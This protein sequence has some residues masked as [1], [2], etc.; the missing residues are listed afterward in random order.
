MRARAKP[1]QP[2]KDER[3]A[4]LVAYL[5]EAVEDLMAGGEAYSDL[6][7]ARPI[8]AVDISRS[9]FYT[10]FDDKIGLL[11]AMGEDVTR[12]LAEAGAHWFELPATATHDELAAVLRAI[13]DAAAYDA[14]M[15]ELHSALV[16]QA[17]TGLQGHIEARQKT[18]RG[19]KPDV[20]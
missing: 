4:R 5:T 9:T 3:R 12:D 7:V 14:G 13:I 6:S 20:R 19:T 16:E 17:A 10:Y 8:T 15:R 18:Q 2:D 1:L 11:R